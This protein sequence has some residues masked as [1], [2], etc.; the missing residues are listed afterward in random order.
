MCVG[1]K[2]ANERTRTNFTISNFGRKGMDFV[3]AILSHTVYIRNWRICI[4]VTK[5]P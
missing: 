2:R 1:M 3:E 5:C 4:I